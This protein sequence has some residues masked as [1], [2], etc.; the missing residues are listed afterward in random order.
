[1]KHYFFMLLIFVF[2]KSTYS[3]TIT[4]NAHLHS[5]KIT[6]TDG[7]T[8]MCIINSTDLDSVF[9]TINNNS[10]SIPKDRIAEIVFYDKFYEQR[11]LAKLNSLERSRI[12]N[13]ATDSLDY[14]LR[15][16][17]YNLRKFHRQF[18]TGLSLSL[19]GSII[20]VGS[21]FI[22][23][24]TDNMNLFY[25]SSGVGAALGTVGLIVQVNSYKWIKKASI[26]PSE[27][28]ISLQIVF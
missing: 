14:E 24:A 27:Y 19:A 16:M 18:L 22:L 28:G 1:M 4:V 25:L 8:F 21:P 23:S 13:N 7:N 5:A 2:V 20:L 15:Y 9:A 17:R 3:Q 11:L 10:F 26:K 6:T 12:L